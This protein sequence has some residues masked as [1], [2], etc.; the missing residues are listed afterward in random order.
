MFHFQGNSQEEWAA[1]LNSSDFKLLCLNGTQAPVT[2]YK[3]C[4][5]AQVPAQT[6]ASCVETR[7]QVLQF[8]KDQRNSPKSIILAIARPHVESD[9]SRPVLQSFLKR[10]QDKTH[11]L[12]PHHHHKY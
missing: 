9:C 12:K 2:D 10:N 4:H 1:G 3:T 11:L 7:G 8:L 5:L 6:F